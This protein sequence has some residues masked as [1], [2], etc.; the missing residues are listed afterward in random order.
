MRSS[1]PSLTVR[2]DQGATGSVLALLALL[3]PPPSVAVTRSSRP[4]PTSE[5]V[6]VY[7]VRVAP[8]IAVHPALQRRQRWVIVGKPAHLPVV[9]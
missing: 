6:G 1:P 3:E 5:A 4:K 8:G 7:L 2:L 9:A